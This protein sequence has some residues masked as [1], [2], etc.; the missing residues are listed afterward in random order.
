MVISGVGGVTLTDS[1]FGDLIFQDTA[2]FDFA[3][4]D[5]NGTDDTT[6]DIITPNGQSITVST[7]TFTANPVHR[8]EVIEE[9]NET[10]GYIMYN[11]FRSN[12]ETELNAAFGELSAANVDHLVLDL[13]YNGGGS[14]LTATR[15]ASMITGQFGN[16]PYANN[17]NG[18][19]RQDENTVFNFNDSLEDGTAVNS[20]NLDKVYVLTTDGSASASELTI[21]ALRPYIEVVQIGTNTSGK[22]TSNRL[23]F[24]SP[25][26]G[27]SQVT[28]AHTYALFP[29]TGNVT[30]INDEEVP[31]T[32]L[33]PNI[34]LEESRANFGTLG[35]PTEP[36]LARAIAEITGNGRFT[37]NLNDSGSLELK[38]KKQEEPLQGYMYYK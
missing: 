3:D 14:I 9:S 22:T 36:L 2:T 11:S 4:Y 19:N 24:D 5:D 8:V 27:T 32:G 31:S 7:E 10:I 1:N 12:F 28:S 35:N 16:Q 25:D 15:L 17:I 29:L 30:N 20:L 26:F 34:L 33:V 23:V 13:R 21:N 6:D 18:P 37:N 38:S